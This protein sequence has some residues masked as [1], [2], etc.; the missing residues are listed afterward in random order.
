MID[1]AGVDVDEFVAVQGF[2]AGRVAADDRFFPD[3]FVVE[4]VEVF[5]FP[6]KD[7]FAALIEVLGDGQFGAEAGVA[8][9]A[10]TSASSGESTAGFVTFSP[11]SFPP[12]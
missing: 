12:W 11:G 10:L 4:G 1:A 3:Q 8:G 6:E 2:G 7:I 5:A 9:T